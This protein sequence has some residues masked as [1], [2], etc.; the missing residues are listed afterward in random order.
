[1]LDK[2]KE[3]ARG[4]KRKVFILYTAY[5]TSFALTANDF[6]VRGFLIGGNV[7]Y[8]VQLSSSTTAVLFTVTGTD[9]FGNLAEDQRFPQTELSFIPQL[10][11]IV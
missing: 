4:L 10:S 9:E 5:V 2:L 8:E 11:P 3:W 7:A 1:M 6:D